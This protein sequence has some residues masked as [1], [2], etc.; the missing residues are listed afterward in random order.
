MKK[1]RDTVT[2]EDVAALAGVSRFTVGRIVGG[3]GS[4]SEK[5]GPITPTIP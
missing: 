3:Y 5:S 1:S 4:V 2:I